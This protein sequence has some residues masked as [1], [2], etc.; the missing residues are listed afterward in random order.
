MSGDSTLSTAT[1]ATNTTTSTFSSILWESFVWPLLYRGSGVMLGLVAVVGSV[2]YYKQDSLLYMP[3]VAGIPRYNRDNPRGY[4]SPNE[5][6]GISSHQELHIP[7]SDGVN[8]HA[9]LLLYTPEPTSST[10][11][12]FS[13]S[14]ELTKSEPQRLPTILVFHGNA[15]NI[16]MRLPMAVLLMQQTKCHV[17]LVEYR[18]YGDS[19]DV[20]HIN[21]VGI[22][23][24]A[25]A[26][27]EY[28]RTSP[29]VQPH[30]DAQQ[31]ILFGQSLGGAVAFF[32][33]NH[34]LQQQQEQ[35]EQ[36]Q[37]KDSNDS[38]GDSSNN[39]HGII[40]IMVENTF[41]SISDMVDVIFPP[42]LTAPLKHFLL[43]IGWNSAHI[44]ANDLRGRI[45][46]LFLAGAK[47]QLVPHPHMLKLHQLALQ[48]AATSG[49]RMVQM[50]IIP[51]GT[52]NESWYQG[53]RAYW[54]AMAKFVQDIQAL[55]SASSTMTKSS[56]TTTT[57]IRS[58]S[59]VSTA[60]STTSSSQT[61]QQQQQPVNI[62]PTSSTRL[63]DIAK[64][65]ITGHG[66]AVQPPT[67]NVAAGSLKADKKN[68]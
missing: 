28:C 7:C 54:K 39:S 57:T 25:V 22:Q 49:A 50:H 37:C 43:R 35:E 68:R 53:G 29:I 63:L 8:I 59:T 26:V 58:D 16:G 34:A 3:V 12:P 1:A 18:G 56:T 5:Q 64:E 66:V 41:T 9:W 11:T 44:V 27:L 52:H 2:L 31:L 48:A 6:R 14:L 55:A 15:G 17:V 23:R 38:N 10:T 19:D 30:I 20:S 13:Q 46:I 47:D 4:R 24:D 62:I 33:A 36:Q 40:G 32:L 67:T 51:N 45:P 61:Q 21:E 60:S 65:V 42:L